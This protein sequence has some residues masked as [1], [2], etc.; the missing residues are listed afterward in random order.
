MPAAE[1]GTGYAVAPA[2]DL[3][4]NKENQPEVLSR[5]Y[6]QLGNSFEQYPLHDD[7]TFY[8]TWQ[9]RKA[10]ISAFTA[11]EGGELP[12]K[13][14]KDIADFLKD[15]LW[16]NRRGLSAA[17]QVRARPAASSRRGH[18]R[19]QKQLRPNRL[20]KRSCLRTWSRAARQQHPRLLRLAQA[21][22]WL[23]ES[24]ALVRRRQR[25]PAAAQRRKRLWKSGRCCCDG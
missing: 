13:S 24:R 16:P 20:A 6:R 22:H 4:I 23:T 3:G 14:V 5:Y 1:A 2:A 17:V 25:V 19:R 18:L 10:V 9:P 15:V 7:G 21:L 8:E 12:A 11:L